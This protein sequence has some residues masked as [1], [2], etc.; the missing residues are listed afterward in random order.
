MRRESWI[1]SIAGAA[2]MLATAGLFVLAMGV[3]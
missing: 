3:F 1:E 2:A